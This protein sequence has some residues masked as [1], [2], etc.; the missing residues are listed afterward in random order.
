MKGG[1]T[2]IMANKEE[3]KKMLDIR[4]ALDQAP[5]R[6]YKYDEKVKES[7]RKLY[8]YE[9]ADIGEVKIATDEIGFTS[10]CFILYAIACLGCPDKMGILLF[11]KALKKNNPS[12]EIADFDMDGLRK[13]LKE[14]FKYG[15]VFRTE[16]RTLE[17]DKNG[18][19]TEYKNTLYTLPKSTQ[20][21]LNYKLQ[22]RTTVNE[23]MS[24][25]P[26]FEMIGW[27]SAAYIST[28]IA[29]SC[30]YIELKQGVYRTKAIGT[31]FIPSICVLENKKKEKV[32]V[33]FIPSYLF[34]AP[35]FMNDTDYQD[36]ALR[37]VNH[38]SQ[39]LYAQ[40]QKKHL[41]RVVVVVE[42]NAD[43]LEIARWIHISNSMRESYPRVY[44][45]GEGAINSCALSD[46]FLRMKASDEN[47]NGFDFEFSTPDFVIQL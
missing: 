42:N 16:Y 45:T 9:Y 10:D 32:Y 26:I 4:R 40:D 23:W 35:E 24:S 19:P 13:R 3:L 11:L 29:N 44:F 38:I 6:K 7:L 30:K 37:V 39:F 15:M 14:L 47:D 18:E 41:A 36:V 46:C 33:G 21:F 25:K 5:A 8:S 12:F 31:M 2:N 1:A 20:K 17:V 43:L 28:I 22:R 27:A 34:K